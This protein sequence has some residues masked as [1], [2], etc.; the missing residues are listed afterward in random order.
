[1]KSSGFGWLRLS[2]LLVFCLFEGL[3]LINTT[4][5]Q[6][7]SGGAS[8]N[9]GNGKSS[10]ISLSSEAFETRLS[11][12]KELL[13][14][15]R[16]DTAHCI[17]LL[18]VAWDSSLFFAF[19][20]CHPF[21]LVALPHKTREL[22][23]HPH[24]STSTLFWKRQKAS[25]WNSP[26]LGLLPQSRI[27]HWETHGMWRNL[28]FWWQLLTQSDPSFLL[29]KSQ[30]SFTPSLLLINKAHFSLSLKKCYQAV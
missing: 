14:S 25:L 9:G 8:S 21:S 18:P 11:P 23:P 4:F 19:F 22:D 7:F 6:T 24:Q 2:S 30:P 29:P 17:S 13:G 16:E 1:M 28:Q 26:Q 5:K 20:S 27:L 10:I 15:R 12:S 3:L